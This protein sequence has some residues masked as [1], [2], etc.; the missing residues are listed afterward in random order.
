MTLLMYSNL[1]VSSLMSEINLCVVLIVFFCFFLMIRRP[2]RSTRT[3]TL[4]PYTT[5]FRS[6]LPV[7]R[8]IIADGPGL[9]VP[10]GER[11]LKHQARPGANGQDRRIGLAPVLAQRRQHHAHDRFIVGEHGLQRIVEQARAIAFGG[12][13]ELIFKAEAVEEIAQHGVVVMGNDLALAERS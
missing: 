11:Y 3:D 6:V 10:L 4:F 9:C 13:D 7:F 1:V 12:G 2:P 8:V 5:L